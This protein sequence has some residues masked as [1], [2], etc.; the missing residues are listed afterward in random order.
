VTL[1]GNEAILL[2]SLRALARPIL[3]GRD[4]RDT[5]GFRQADRCHSVDR[6]SAVESRLA[7]PSHSALV[8]IGCKPHTSAS[9]L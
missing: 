8:V 1:M 2:R 5:L 7:L 6:C 9:C 4:C 3:I